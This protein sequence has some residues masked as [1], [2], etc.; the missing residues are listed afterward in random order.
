MGKVISLYKNDEIE[1]PQEQ[2]LVNKEALLM[3]AKAFN[4]RSMLESELIIRDA[5]DLHNSYTTTKED[6]YIFSTFQEAVCSFI[7][8]SSN[9]KHC[10][11]KESAWN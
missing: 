2:D 4:H 10:I 9:Y 1:E 3:M 7:N 5:V 6:K 8:N 11:R